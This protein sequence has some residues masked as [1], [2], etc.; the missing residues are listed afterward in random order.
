MEDQAQILVEEIK[1]ILKQYVNE[2]GPGGR[3]VWPRA[4]RGRATKLSDLL[5]SKRS[6]ELTGLP[7]DT[8]YAWRAD[9]KKASH[10][11]LVVRN[12]KDKFATVTVTDKS[13]INPNE[14]SVT[15]TVTTPNG[16]LIEGLPAG[17]AIDFLLKI[18][19]G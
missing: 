11:S 1:Q 14:N 17:M 3:K 13:P 4:I 15:V 10:K 5:G 8:L 9:A 12:N 2:V 18:G 16:F 19:V 6:A 7:V